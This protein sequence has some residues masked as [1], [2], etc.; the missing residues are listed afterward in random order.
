MIRPKIKI[1]FHS[2]ILPMMD[3][4][5]DSLETS[6]GQ[7]AMLREQGIETVASTSHFYRHNEDL[8][9][10]LLRREKQAAVLRDYIE[11][12]Q[13]DVPEI[14][15]GAEVNIER[16]L[17]GDPALERLKLAGT[18][19]ILLEI[20][21]TGYKDWMAA[22]VYNICVR[23][24]AK[25]MLAHLDRYMGQL[26]DEQLGELLSLDD[27]VI[28]INTSAFDFRP[29]LKFVLELANDGYPLV[30]GSD[31][32]NL[33]SRA[34]NFDSANKALL[35]KLKADRFFA[36]IRQQSKILSGNA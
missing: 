17:L 1:D 14:R 28:Q 4:G 30:F 33:T 21:Y 36:M 5:S 19:Y 16:D 10:F 23:H 15:L 26:T 2:H 35:S 27:L 24:H 18:D 12:K 29:G 8:T 6:A 32:H 22:E 7:L 31:T 3:D 13:L 25:P 34:P 9:S 11:E 20:P